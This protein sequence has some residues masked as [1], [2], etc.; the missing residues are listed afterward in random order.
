MDGELGVRETDAHLVECSINFFIH[1][2][3]DI[4]VILTLDPDADADIYAAVGQFFQ[5][6]EGGGRL[7]EDAVKQAGSELIRFLRIKPEP[8]VGTVEAI[9]AL[10]RKE[11]PCAVVVLGGCG[12][13]SLSHGKVRSG[14]AGTFRSSPLQ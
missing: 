5:A 3:E 2:E 13:C 8:A 14:I 7:L 12:G 11:R 10:I 9:Y 4:P 6:D 1:V